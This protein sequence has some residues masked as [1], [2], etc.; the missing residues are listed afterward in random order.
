MNADLGAVKKSFYCTMVH[1]FVDHKL[2]QFFY[3][4]II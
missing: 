2:C 3:D 4:T 1:I